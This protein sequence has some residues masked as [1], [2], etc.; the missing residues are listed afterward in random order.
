[1]QKVTFLIIPL[2]F[3]SCSH[4]APQ[5]RKPSSEEWIQFDP[6]HEEMLPLP[7][8]QCPPDTQLKSGTVDLKVQQCLKNYIHEKT[9]YG[10]TRSRICFP[11]ETKHE[12][13]LRFPPKNKIY[14][15]VLKKVYFPTSEQDASVVLL[16]N[17]AYY[18]LKWDGPA[19]FTAAQVKEKFK[20]TPLPQKV[21]LERCE[22]DTSQFSNDECMSKLAPLLQQEQIYKVGFPQ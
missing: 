5:A 16:L 7:A 15:S 3:I 4:S 22:C 9:E 20:N 17:H 6:D 19:T 14:A 1:M 18:S 8:S 21:T 12:A 10:V 13:Q 11:P 2:I